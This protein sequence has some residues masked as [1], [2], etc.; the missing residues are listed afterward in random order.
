MR[1]AFKIANRLSFCFYSDLPPTPGRTGITR[2][3]T[4]GELPSSFTS[5]TSA[6]RIS[7]FQAVR[8]GPIPTIPTS[9]LG[10]SEVLYPSDFDSMLPAPPLAAAGDVSDHIVSGIDISHLEE[11][12]SEDTDNED[13]FA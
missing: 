11:S 1:S 4:T 5:V 2:A 13:P 10:G 8:G 12:D 9:Q 3:S 7:P 6:G